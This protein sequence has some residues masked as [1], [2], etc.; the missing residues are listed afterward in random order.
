[1]QSDSKKKFSYT[2]VIRG[3]LDGGSVMVRW[4]RDFVVA[5]EMSRGSCLRQLVS[6]LFA[7]YALMTCNPDKGWWGLS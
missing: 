1:M 3:L 4:M 2:M 6:G 5:I 7:C